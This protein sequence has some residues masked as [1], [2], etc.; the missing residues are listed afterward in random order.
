MLHSRKT[1]RITLMLSSAYQ[2]AVY[3]FGHHRHMSLIM[4]EPRVPIPNLRMPLQA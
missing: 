1:Y 2:E 4:Q 3:A